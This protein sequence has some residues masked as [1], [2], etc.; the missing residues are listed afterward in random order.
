LWGDSGNRHGHR[1]TEREARFANR[2]FRSDPN[3]MRT[4]DWTEEMDFH[5]GLMAHPAF[6]CG[7]RFGKVA[8]QIKK[9]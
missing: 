5:G 8:L 6:A 9:E 3:D 1:I 2:P 7:G 4:T